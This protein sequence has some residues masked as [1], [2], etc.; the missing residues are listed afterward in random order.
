MH[1]IRGADG[2]HWWPPSQLQSTASC[3]CS[4]ETC[5]C[6]YCFVR[7]LLLRPNLVT[8]YFFTSYH[9]GHYRSQFIPAR[10]TDRFK[11]IRA[12]DCIDSWNKSLYIP[13]KVGRV[14]VTSCVAGECFSHS[15][16]VILLINVAIFRLKPCLIYCRK[17]RSCS[18]TL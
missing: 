17:T 11:S 5:A 9:C 15:A 2:L 8:G 6:D 13:P 1:W 12:G 4:V 14:P 16:T 3:V 10:H 18:I 7:H